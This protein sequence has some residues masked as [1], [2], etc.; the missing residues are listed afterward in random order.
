MDHGIGKIPIQHRNADGLSKRTN[1]CRWGERQ[2]EKLPPVAE[3]WNFLSQDEYERLSTA[4]WF[5][6]Q[7]RVI[8]NHPEFSILLKNLQPNPP[9]LVQRVIR[10]S[11]RAKRHAKRNEA[12]HSP[13]PSP[14]PAI[15]H[16]H[17]D[18]YP[19]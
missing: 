16:A 6:Q 9:D 12:L 13:L 2:L 18:F 8:P 7:G 11:K 1:D 19:D 4:P 15:L 3:R 17:E 10:R 14:P 5:H